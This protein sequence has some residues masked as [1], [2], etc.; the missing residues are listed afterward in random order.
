MIDGR[1]P[2]HW[3]VHR[4]HRLR[5]FCHQSSAPDLSQGYRKTADHV[6][7]DPSNFQLRVIHG[8]LPMNAVG[9]NGPPDQE[10][11]RSHTDQLRPLPICSSKAR[12]R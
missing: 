6:P 11:P 2:R 10:W 9:A 1:I 5:H 12:F 8:N 7:T 4:P 3:S